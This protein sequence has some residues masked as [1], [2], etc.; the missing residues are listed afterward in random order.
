M[1]LKSVFPTSTYHKII[2][3]MEYHSYM[4]LFPPRRGLT[5]RLERAP[6]LIYNAYYQV[7]EV[8]IYEDAHIIILGN[9]ISTIWAV[10]GDGEQVSRLKR[11]CMMTHVL[12]K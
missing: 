8:Y 4:L 6:V 5:V 1:L 3:W 10:I 2:Q 7:W 9:I 11:F 12:F